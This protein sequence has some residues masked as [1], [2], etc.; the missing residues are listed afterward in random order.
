[1]NQQPTNEEETEEDSIPPVII[2][3]GPSGLKYGLFD[4]TDGTWLSQEGADGPNIYDRDLEINGVPMSAFKQAQCAAL[5]ASAQFS[6]HKIYRIQAKL[7]PNGNFHVKDTVTSERAGA[8]AVEV[9]E[10]R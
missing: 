1:M 10:R 6:K 8:E 3:K 4:T 2:D 7:I 5:I 9:L